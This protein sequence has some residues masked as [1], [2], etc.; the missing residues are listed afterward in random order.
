MNSCTLKIAKVL[1]G[2]RFLILP[3]KNVIP[4]VGKQAFD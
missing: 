3:V 1:T 2:N 4:K